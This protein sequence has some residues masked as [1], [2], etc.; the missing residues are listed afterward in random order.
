MLMR[1]GNDTGDATNMCSIYGLLQLGVPNL[2]MDINALAGMI[3][4]RPAR[5][6]LEHL[7]PRQGGALRAKENSDFAEA[8]RL[9]GSQIRYFFETKTGPTVKWV[10]SASSQS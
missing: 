9:P 7:N 8:F 1:G 3:K 4:N 10:C 5:H 2:G 6:V